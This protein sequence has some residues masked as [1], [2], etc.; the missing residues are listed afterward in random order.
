[1]VKVVGVLIATGSRQH[2]RTQ[3]VGRAVC[4]QQRIARI[5]NQRPKAVGDAEFVLYRSE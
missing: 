4:Q 5:G 2:P 3:Y 1:M